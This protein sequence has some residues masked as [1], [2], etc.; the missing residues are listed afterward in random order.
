MRLLRQRRREG[1]VCVTV[2]VFRCEIDRMA[3]LGLLR[4]DQVRER[5]AV[6]IA[7]GKIVES[8][9]YANRKGRPGP[10]SID[11]LALNSSRRSGP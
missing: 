6:T 9:F 10:I 5:E 7:V 1:A 8:W 3:R 11:K 2:E 4:A